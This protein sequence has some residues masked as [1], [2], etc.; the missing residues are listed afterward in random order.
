MGWIIAGAVIAVLVVILMIPVYVGIEYKGELTVRISYLFVKI[1]V[2]PLKEKNK[3]KNKAKKK[4]EAT[5]GDKKEKGKKKKQS[6]MDILKIITDIIRSIEGKLKKVII[7]SDIK[8][9][10]EV[11]GDDAC[12]TALSY[13]KAS[14]G[15]NTALA[16]LKNLITVKRARVSVFPNFA[17]EENK[18][19]VLVKFRIIPAAAAIAVIRII[20]SYIKINME[21]NQTT[22][23]LLQGNNR[24]IGGK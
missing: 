8:V 21:E 20:V 16:I 7:I 6:V 13:G 15:I 14:A 5:E 1:K 24:K 12:D 17:G 19:Y 22:S 2:F 18:T 23:L 10:M 3:G 11:V 4:K 9:F